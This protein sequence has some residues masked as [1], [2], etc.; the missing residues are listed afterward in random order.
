MIHEC[1]IKDHGASRFILQ[2]L[3]LCISYTHPLYMK[4][5][6]MVFTMI[7]EAAHETYYSNTIQNLRHTKNGRGAWLALITSHVGGMGQYHK[8]EQ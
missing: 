1:Q 6:A 4:D 7:K 3:I 2:D 8:T 5:N